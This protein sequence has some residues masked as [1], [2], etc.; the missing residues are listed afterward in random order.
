MRLWHRLRRI[1]LATLG[2][3]LIAT[4]MLPQLGAA[5]SGEA[6]ANRVDLLIVDETK[7][8][9]ASLVVNALAGGLKRT[10]QFNVQAV[11]PDVGSSYEDPLGRNTGEAQYEI[12]LV[13]PRVDV[14]FGLGQLWIA[15]CGIPHQASSAVIDG[16]TTMQTMIERNGQMGIQALSVADDAMPGY[17]AALFVQHGWLRCGSES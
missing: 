17:F 9:Q 15:T 8:F 6:D 4:L 3:L 5:Q 7:T 11:F 13:V 14:L 10:G 1:A 16:V 2:P 12:V